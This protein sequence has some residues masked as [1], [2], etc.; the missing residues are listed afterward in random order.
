MFRFCRVMIVACALPSALSAQAVK[1]SCLPADA[2]STRI[3]QFFGSLVTPATTADTAE[4]SRLKLDDV[5]PAQIVRV[6][7]AHLCFK[8]G[9][10]MN[11][12]AK[13]K[14]EEFQLY[15]VRVGD[16][17]AVMDTTWRSGEYIPVALFDAHWKLRDILLS[18]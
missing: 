7:D 17:Y 11:K 4:R 10:A 2:M 3:V 13:S 8:A 6:S 18:F 15:V 16:A 1:A 14:Q 12:L 5:T 9:Q